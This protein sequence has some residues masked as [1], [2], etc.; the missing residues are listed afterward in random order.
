MRMMLLLFTVTDGVFSMRLATSGG[1]RQI[2]SR[3]PDS[4][5][6]YCVLASGSTRTTSF[7][8]AGLGPK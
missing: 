2:Q 3:P 6:A 8:T 1:T 4:S 7:C 5:S